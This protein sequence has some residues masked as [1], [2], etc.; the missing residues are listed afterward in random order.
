MEPSR[1]TYNNRRFEEDM[2]F[3]DLEWEQEVAQQRSSADYQRRRPVNLSA[4]IEDY[5]RSFN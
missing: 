1:Y 4:S 5:L 3:Q 2:A